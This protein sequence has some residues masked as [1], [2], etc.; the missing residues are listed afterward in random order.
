[1][2][3]VV[4]L[5]WYVPGVCCVY[6]TYVATTFVGW[7][8]GMACVHLF[9]A[10][11]IYRSSYPGGGAPRVVFLNER[12]KPGERGYLVCFPGEAI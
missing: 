6:T 8:L 1:M 10:N 11:R 5:F 9:A 3:M 7:T 2:K 12:Q 4:V